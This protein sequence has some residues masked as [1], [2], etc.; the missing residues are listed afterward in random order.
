M[1]KKIIISILIA[2][3]IFLRVYQVDQVPGGLFGDEVS[4][5]INAKTIAQSGT[6]EYGKKFPF[7]IESFSDYKMPGYVYASIIPFDI[8]GP[9][10]LSIRFVSLLSS[11]TSIFL[12][13]YLAKL[14]FP[15]K[16]YIAPTAAVILALSPYHIHFGRIAYETMLATT[17]LLGFLIA[18]MQTIKS[19]RKALWFIV[20]A[21]LLL[22]ACW[23]YPAEQFIIPVFL[24]GIFLATVI[25]RPTDVSIK[26]TLLTTTGFLGFS[27]L[28]F[29]P[30]FLNPQIN[31]R[32]LGYVFADK[33]AIFIKLMKVASSYLRGFNLEFLFSKGDIFAYRSGTKTVGIFL[34]IFLPTF[35]A[36]FFILIRMFRKKEFSWFVFVILLLVCGLPSALTWDVPYG[37]RFL[38]MII[39]LTLLLSL[40]CEAL[41]ET[42][43]KQKKII[44]IAVSS[45]L[46]ALLLYQIAYFTDA[47][48]VRFAI[49]SEPEFVSSTKEMSLYVTD[50]A[51]KNPNNLVYFLND[52][53]CASWR[54]ET[55][56]LWY[57]GNLDN[58]K[59]TV[60]D[61]KYRDQRVATGNP[62]AAYDFLPTPEGKIDNII[63]HPSLEK[64]VSA[65]SGS[66]LVHCG[67]SLPDLNPKTEKIEKVFYLYPET[68]KSPE[69]VVSKRL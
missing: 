34:S 60:W 9:T 11:I 45:V 23:T 57:F 18:F 69:Y 15:K 1:V 40:G 26:I 55:L 32:T 7:G 36:G 58:K 5:G 38:P 56:H 48:F 47:Y 19:T 62:F 17:L 53:Q 29:I 65:S 16:K 25:F 28:S 10:I 52:T 64:M 21:I 44:R 66:L 41:F 3:G 13:G 63:L 4:L 35:L 27:L 67:I 30:G 61:K 2:F 37:P 50:F 51:K 24:V 20:G 59:M 33:N 68:Q 46:L 8:F 42:L 31:K 22:A 49:T 39:P 12:I 43:G 6:D 54:Y 14:L